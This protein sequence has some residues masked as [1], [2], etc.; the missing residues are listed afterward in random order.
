[1]YIWNPPP[2]HSNG[3]PFLSV[4]YTSVTLKWRNNRDFQF[5]STFRHSAVVRSGWPTQQLWCGGCG[6]HG[7]VRGSNPCRS[8]GTGCFNALFLFY[9]TFSK[10]L[11]HQKT[12]CW[13]W[14]LFEAGRI[15]GVFD[16]LP[17]HGCGHVMI[18]HI[19]PVNGA[20]FFFLIISFALAE[21]LSKIIRYCLLL[22]FRALLRSL[23]LFQNT[24]S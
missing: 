17:L 10:W 3:W 4:L 2:I 13:C 23:L 1:M 5:H 24:E 20:F 9:F 22:Q 21:P 11:W 18:S 7:H 19:L 15:P 12:P 8:S 6:L 14:S 16:S